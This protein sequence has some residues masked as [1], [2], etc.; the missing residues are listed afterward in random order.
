[1]SKF[2]TI[3]TPAYNRGILLYN[4]YDSLLKQTC[5][6]F[7]W[8]IIDDGSNDNTEEIVEQFIKERLI[9][10]RYIKKINGGKHTALNIAFKKAEGEVL[11]ILDS[12]DKLT[13]DAVEII[14]KVWNENKNI[15]GLASISFLRSYSNGRII[16]DR[17]PEDFYLSNYIDCRINSNIKGDKSEVYSTEIIKNF[18][19]PEIEGEKFIG[20]GII[21]TK[22]GRKYK[23]LYINKA[24]YITEYL[25]GGLT[26]S[27]RKLRINCPEGGRLNAK[28]GMCREVILKMRIKYSILYVCY[29]FFAEKNIR[30]IIK[31]NKYKCI[32]LINIFP[33]YLLFKY[34][35]YKYNK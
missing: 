35:N 20:E 23:E 10:I 33:G 12:D 24:I 5:K 2:L 30:E 13:N 19:F 14:S 32:T 1:M 22:L 31:D 25:E 29:S 6:N 8:L 28:E 26:N 17:F 4:C 34:W 16:G 3:V 21:W 27:G 9:K 11:L 15:D 18:S 7:E